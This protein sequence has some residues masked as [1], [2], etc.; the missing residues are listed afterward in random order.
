MHDGCIIS[1]PIRRPLLVQHTNYEDVW[2]FKLVKTSV[3]HFSENCQLKKMGNKK[4][5]RHLCLR[6]ILQTA[7]QRLSH[8]WSPAYAAADELKLLKGF[9]RSVFTTVSFD[10]VHFNRK[11]L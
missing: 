9:E 5:H 8:S 4:P 2:N 7:V 6:E 11:H 1:P 10:S 3:F